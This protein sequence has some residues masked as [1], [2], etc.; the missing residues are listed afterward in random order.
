[1]RK[2]IFIAVFAF[3]L[4]A[5]AINTPV[6]HA[7]RDD[8]IYINTPEAYLLSGPGT[9]YRIL[10]KITRDDPLIVVYWRGDWFQ[11]E[12]ADG[13]QGWI[14]R[15]VLSSADSEEYPSYIADSPNS[16][17]S[18][19]VL[20][21]LK[22]GFKGSGD[23]SI[24]A[25]AGGRGIDECDGPGDYYKDFESVNFMESIVIPDYEIEKFIDAGGLEK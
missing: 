23:G 22:H 14:N 21:R 2:N 24:T 20:D 4:L 5:A 13:T 8:Y 10:C 15:V 9:E 6:A 18:G 7:Q 17:T 3:S 11:V 16:G 12:K 1:M 19:S 25:S